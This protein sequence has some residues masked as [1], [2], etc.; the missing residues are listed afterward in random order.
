[1]RRDKRNAP[2]PK[3]HTMHGKGGS[4]PRLLVN[5]VDGLRKR[6]SGSGT[7]SPDGQDSRFWHVAI[8]VACM[9]SWPRP[10]FLDLSVPKWLQGEWLRLQGSFSS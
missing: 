8:D 2:P 1:M 3:K 5:E 9:L 7:P 4:G 10:G 6:A